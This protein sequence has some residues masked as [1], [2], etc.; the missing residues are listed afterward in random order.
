VPGPQR[1]RDRIQFH[2][3]AETFYHQYIRLERK[4]LH[5]VRINQPLAIVSRYSDRLDAMGRSLILRT[6]VPTDSTEGELHTAKLHHMNSSFD[7]IGLLFYVSRGV[8]GN[9]GVRC[10]V[11]CSRAGDVDEVR[12]QTPPIAIIPKMERSARN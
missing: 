8:R 6:G 2:A 3:D 5:T 9:V 12:P 11:R 4:S 1:R 10:S 7:G